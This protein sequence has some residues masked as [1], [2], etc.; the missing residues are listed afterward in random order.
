[1]DSNSQTTSAK[2]PGDPCKQSEGESIKQAAGEELASSCEGESD[3][4]VREGSKS[5][6]RETL[7]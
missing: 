2:W 7:R 4:T 3:F 6:T 5:H 1:M